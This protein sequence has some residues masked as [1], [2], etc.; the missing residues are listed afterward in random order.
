M[1]HAQARVSCVIWWLLAI[2]I[3]TRGV[4]L[5]LLQFWSG[6]DAAAEHLVARDRRRLLVHHHLWHRPDEH[7]ALQRSPH[8]AA[9]QTVNRSLDMFFF[10]YFRSLVYYYMSALLNGFSCYI[11]QVSTIP[12]CADAYFLWSF[13]NT[14]KCAN[15]WYDMDVLWAHLCAQSQRNIVPHVV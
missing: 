13:Q 7:A 9:G 4:Y 12:G 14:H 8:A 1:H 11:G 3:V 5:S 2:I 10:T 15:T 6:S